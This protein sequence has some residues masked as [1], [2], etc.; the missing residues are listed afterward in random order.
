MITRQEHLQ[1]C[2]DRAMQYVNAGDFSQAVASMASDLDKH[3]ETAGVASFAGQLGLMELM[4]GTT[5]EK[6]VHFIEGF[7]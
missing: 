5:R 1:W 7:R 4:L 3:P 2:K 6:M